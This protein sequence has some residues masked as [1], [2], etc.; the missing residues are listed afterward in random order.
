MLYIN[1][2]AMSFESDF[3]I[4]LAQVSFY[5]YIIHRF[6]PPMQTNTYKNSQSSVSQVCMIPATV[7]EDIEELRG[8]TRSKRIGSKLKPGL[9]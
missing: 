6:P 1:S 4:F 3:I 8:G 9:A 7:G 2:M 5:T